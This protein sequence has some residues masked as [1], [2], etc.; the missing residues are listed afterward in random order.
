MK[1]AN[2]KNIAALLAYCGLY[3]A[4]Q[5]D[6]LRVQGSYEV[7][8]FFRFLGKFGFQMT[9]Q[10]AIEDTQGFIYGNITA[11]NSSVTQGKEDEPIPYPWKAGCATQLA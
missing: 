5:V 9:D 7:G 11:S 4:H 8:E 6:S 1:K 2:V 3:F 10:N